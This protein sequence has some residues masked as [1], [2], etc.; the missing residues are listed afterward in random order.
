M[1]TT[2]LPAGTRVRHYGH[3]W[4]AAVRDGTGNIREAKGPYPDG[5]YEYLV[6]VEDGRET[7]RWWASYATIHVFPILADHT[8]EPQ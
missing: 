7:P 1:A 3:Q 6:D 2:P 4:A 8:K 5:S